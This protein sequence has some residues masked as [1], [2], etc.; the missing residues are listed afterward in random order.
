MPSTLCGRRLFTAVAVVVIWVQH[1]FLYY[2]AT[3]ATAHTPYYQRDEI[4]Q[5]ARQIVDERGR[6]RQVRQEGLAAR[7]PDHQRVEP[8]EE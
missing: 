2:T 8:G 5:I 7:D 1:N 6:R 3:A 4:A